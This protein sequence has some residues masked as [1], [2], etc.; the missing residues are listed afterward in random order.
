MA[1]KGGLGN[2]LSALFDDNKTEGSPAQTLRISE[3]EPNR[4]QPR[5]NF[6]DESISV[7]AD[8][9]KQHGVL[10]PLLVRPYGSGYQIVAGERRWRAARMLGLSEVPV[11][12]RELSDIETMQI[13]LIENLQRENL[14][15]IEEAKGYNELIENYDMTQEE[16][17]KTVGRSRS[18]VS[19]SM[20][21]L[22]LPDEVLEMLEKGDISVGHGKA[23]L[24][25]DDEE[26]MLEAA[27]KAAEGKLNV[28]ALEKMANEEEK[29][30]PVSNERVDS[31]F[32]EMEI[33]LN[34]T[35]G[36]KVKVE[37]GKNKGA[38]IL[39]FYDKD[40]LSELAKKLSE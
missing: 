23:L 38:L 9:I 36:R 11:Q 2:G 20:R 3:I 29:E 39:E 35:L 33:S 37:Y 8:S 40:D 32:K 16:V 30:K 28:R 27:R 31:Y 17:A 19:N 4:D 7:L 12:V 24:S 34:D 18:A 1:R 10:Q 15:P 21:L 13:A 25:F 14:N 6:D 22:S 26:K 5:K